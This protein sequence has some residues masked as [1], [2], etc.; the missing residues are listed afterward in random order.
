M[1]SS[2][3]QLSWNKVDLK[4]PSIGLLRGW[5]QQG[6]GFIMTETRPLKDTTNSIF[7]PTTKA[8]KTLK[9]AKLLTMPVESEILHFCVWE[10]THQHLLDMRIASMKRNCYV[11]G[12]L[13]NRD[14]LDLHDFN[15]FLHIIIL[16][17]I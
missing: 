12:K 9:L 14:F 2:G 13:R 3:L 8:K 5:G 10:H 16:V 1:K 7:M 6:L 15:F 4:L 17:H 11:M